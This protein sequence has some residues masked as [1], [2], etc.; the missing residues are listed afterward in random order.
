MSPKI[1][2][3][4]YISEGKRIKIVL[5]GSNINSKDVIRAY[6]LL[7]IMAGKN[8]SKKNNSSNMIW[9]VIKRRFNNGFW[10]SSKDLKETIRE[11]LGIDIPINSI[12]TY[13]LRFY[14]RGLLERKGNKFGMRYRLSN[15]FIANSQ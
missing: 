8:V 7:R 15:S 2:I 11:E 3:E 14:R 12:A 4:D 1:S 6:E 10:F 5:E 13:L 9:K